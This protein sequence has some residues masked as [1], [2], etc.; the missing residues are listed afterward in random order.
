MSDTLKKILT[1]A[2]IVVVVLFIVGKL[3]PQKVRDF[4]GW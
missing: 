2:V 3:A 1:T 4:V